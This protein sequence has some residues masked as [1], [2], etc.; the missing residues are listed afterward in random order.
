MISWKSLIKRMPLEVK[1]SKD[2]IWPIVFVKDFV[3]GKTLGETRFD[4]KQIAILMG[5]SDKQ[6]IHTY[7]HEILHAFSETYGANLTET[8]ILALEKG[9]SYILKKG[10]LFKE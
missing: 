2:D 10:N 8:Q 5:Q 9:I 4:P 1:T 7:L 6:T 3:D